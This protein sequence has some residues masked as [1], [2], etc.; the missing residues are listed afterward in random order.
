[1]TVSVSDA[2]VAVVLPSGRQGFIVEIKH[3]LWFVA[4]VAK[5][6]LFQVSDIIRSHSI[7]HLNSEELTSV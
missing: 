2:A 3:F 1:M 4:M 5:I 7:Q 6:N